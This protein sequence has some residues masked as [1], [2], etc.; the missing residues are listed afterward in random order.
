MLRTDLEM[1]AVDTSR[2][3]LEEGLH[4]LLELCCFN[5]IQDLLHFV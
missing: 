2:K 4:N 3:L 5:D 1:L